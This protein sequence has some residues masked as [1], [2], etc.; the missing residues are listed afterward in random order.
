MGTVA[1]VAGGA[2]AGLRPWL[3]PRRRYHRPRSP[4]HPEGDWGQRWAI[5]PALMQ[6]LA[7]PGGGAGGSVALAERADASDKGQDGG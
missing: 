3:P 7:P 1:T 5:V 4:A 2:G 6:L